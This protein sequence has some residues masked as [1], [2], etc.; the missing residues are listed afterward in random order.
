MIGYL[1][2]DKETFEKNRDVLPL[3]FESAKKHE[4]FLQALILE[5][6]EFIY[7]NE[8]IQILSNNIQLPMP[9]FVIN[10]TRQFFVGEFFEQLG[11]KVFNDSKV[12]RITNDKRLA[13]NE[14]GRIGIPV[15]KTVVNFTPQKEVPFYPIIAKNPFGHG[16]NEVYLLNDSI[17]RKEM[18]MKY[19]A[20]Y[21]KPCNNP[22]RDV[23]VY[24]IGNE[25]VAAILRISDN[26]FRSNYS[27]GGNVSIYDLSEEEK[28]IV[29]KIIKHFTF[30][31]VG[32]DFIFD[33][34]KFVFNE[35][36]DVVGA[37]MLYKTTNIDIIDLYMKHIA[38]NMNQILI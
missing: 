19:N 11:V 21:Q 6:M 20:V 17:Q 27:L 22:G 26:D 33:D 34:G 3:Y 10:R 24:V 35:I 25:V 38:V 7:D 15:M 29:E 36:E 23:R 4:L 32:V 31:M 5:E 18:N 1:I 12:T 9:K 8:N 30:G 16:G 37:R 28:R 13:Y 2:Y 14:I